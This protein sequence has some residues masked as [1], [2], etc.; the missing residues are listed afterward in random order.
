MCLIAVLLTLSGCGQAKP[1]DTPTMETTVQASVQETE[2]EPA[3]TE[4]ETSRAEANDT[5]TE[6]EATGMETEAESSESES[7][8]DVSKTETESANGETST[9]AS[10]EEES[11]K[12][13]S[14]A[15][16]E[17]SAAQTE[18]AGKSVNDIYDEITQS[19]TLNSPMVLPDD[20]ISNYYGIDLNSLEEYVFSMSEASVSAEM[21]VLVK[22]KDSASIQT[23]TAAL[24]TV[25]DQKRS[26]M[27]NYLP[28][29]FQIVDKS[30]VQVKGNYVYLVISEQADSI[31][32]MIQAGIQ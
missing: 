32:R 27:E 21:I 7:T 16:K 1:A 19:V 5:D 2:S 9:T 12:E 17:E 14:T 10:V 24:Q 8:A 28:D 6:T 25:I 29:Q 3:K 13:E 20:Y 15:A 18:A 11:K 30:S 31:T 23:L 22:A 4:A 26:E